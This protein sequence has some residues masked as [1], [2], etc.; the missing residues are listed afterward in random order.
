M[1]SIWLQMVLTQANSFRVANQTSTLNLDFEIILSSKRRCLNVLINSP[2][3]PFTTTVLL[4]TLTSTKTETVNKN[5][6]RAVVKGHNLLCSK[7][8]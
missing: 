5:V 1:F 6:A 4:L 3:G 7:K 8:S 2:L